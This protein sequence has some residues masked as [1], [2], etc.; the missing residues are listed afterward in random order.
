MRV[1]TNQNTRQKAEEN[2]EMQVDD[3]TMNRKRTEIDHGRHGNLGHSTYHDKD[4]ERLEEDK[5]LRK[6]AEWRKTTRLQRRTQS[7]KTKIAG[8]KILVRRMNLM[9]K[10][11]RYP[12]CSKVYL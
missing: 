4:H 2:K 3:K 5:K 8:G 11:K 9:R 6:K 10:P 1:P 12:M 7:R